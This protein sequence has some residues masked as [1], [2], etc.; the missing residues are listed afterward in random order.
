[1]FLSHAR[2]LRLQSSF[3]PNSHRP[4]N[5]RQ[6]GEHQAEGEARHEAEWVNPSRYDDENY[7]QKR[8]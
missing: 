8:V 4:G 2:G 3:R 5:N 6:I 7:F 1:M